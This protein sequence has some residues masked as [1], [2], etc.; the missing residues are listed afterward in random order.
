MNG[1][2]EKRL[3]LVGLAAVISWS[4]FAQADTVELRYNITSG[5]VIDDEG[6]VFPITGGTYSV[7]YQ[8][9][10][11]GTVPISGPA[12]LNSFEF[13]ASGQSVSGYAHNTIRASLPSPSNGFGKLG[14]I[15]ENTQGL[16]NMVGTLTVHCYAV[17]YC[18]YYGLVTSVPGQ[19]AL[20]FTP[21]Q[22]ALDI[23]AGNL[24]AAGPFTAPPFTFGSVAISAIGQ[25]I[26]R[27]SHLDDR[28]T[29][30]VAPGGSP[31]PVATSGTVSVSVMAVDT[32]AH[33]LTFQWSADCPAAL[34][35]DGTFANPSVAATQWTAPV[36]PTASEQDCTISVLVTDGAFGQSDNDSFLQTVPEPGASVLGMS[37]LATLG[38]L[39]YRRGGTA[40]RIRNHG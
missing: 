35:A 14:S 25:E 17:G 3:L 12:V 29:I 40:V 1:M 37:A 13:Q 26:A 4:S 34:P 19:F 22:S 38:V 8:S 23:A 39:G 7:T 9:A 30:T 16:L 27:I 6:G 36:N 28:V 2:N 31:N 24:A 10:I 11:S 15:F 5:T 18:Q 21:A 33:P 32:M 20:D